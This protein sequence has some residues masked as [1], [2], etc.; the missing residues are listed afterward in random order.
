MTKSE[1]KRENSP[2]NVPDLQAGEREEMPILA[3]PHHLAAAA[4]LRN[5]KFLHQTADQTLE[6]PQ[7]R[8]RI[9]CNRR[10][11]LLKY[12]PRGQLCAPMASCLSASQGGQ[13]PQPGVNARA[14]AVKTP[15][16]RLPFPPRGTRSS[17][18][19]QFQHAAAATARLPRD[20]E[21]RPCQGGGR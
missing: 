13:V 6:S 7:I 1:H 3:G 16:A 4:S 21:L 19:S 15:P 20:V 14:R 11:F 12:L 8:V 5:G 9:W 2:K 17:M 18:A 10:G